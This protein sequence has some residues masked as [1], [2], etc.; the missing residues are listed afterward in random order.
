MKQVNVQ[1]KYSNNQDHSA[2]RDHLP[3][4]IRSD[5][6]YNEH[7][8]IVSFYCDLLETSNTK[9]EYPKTY[10]SLQRLEDALRNGPVPEFY[11]CSMKYGD[12]EEFESQ[13]YITE[14]VTEVVSNFIAECKE[15]DV[16]TSL[17][18]NV[19]HFVRG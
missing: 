18:F 15:D 14:C 8:E 9:T 3:F 17:V 4:E 5:I 11:E 12:E 13:E 10:E 7:S 1:N 6:S 2:K 19:N 16:R